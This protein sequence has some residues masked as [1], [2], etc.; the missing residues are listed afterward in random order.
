MN[1]NLDLTEETN[2]VEFYLCIIVCS[3]GISSNIFNIF[4]CARKEL[5]IISMGYFNIIMSSFN[6]LTLASFFVL[7]FPQS[8]G[9]EPLI[10]SSIYCCILLPYIGRIF[11]TTS[12]W[13]NILVT[14]DR[15]LLVSARSRFA[16]HFKHNKILNI[17][18]FYIP[19]VAPFQ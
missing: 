1:Q 6:I 8:I 3:L 2:Q 19:K 12:I 16:H 9:L 14:L 11:A 7:F 10:L 18:I 17:I 5:Q 4:V 13:I 15:I